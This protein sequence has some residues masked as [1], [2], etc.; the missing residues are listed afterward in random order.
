MHKEL[1]QKVL[2]YL[3]ILK[4]IF[5]GCVCSYSEIDFPAENRYKYPKLSRTKTKENKRKEKG[6]ASTNS[7]SLFR[8]SQGQT[9]SGQPCGICR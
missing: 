5:M 8:E 4:I 3:I 9:E 2:L 6:L 7:F 1:M